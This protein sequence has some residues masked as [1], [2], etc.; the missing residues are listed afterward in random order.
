MHALRK[1]D[2]GQSLR[3]LVELD[4][5]HLGSRK[6][7]QNAVEAAHGAATAELGGRHPPP[8]SASLG[9]AEPA[10]RDCSAHPRSSVPHRLVYHCAR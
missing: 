4:D 9:E 2:N 8:E 3:G 1:W 7:G 6:H 10:A 5:T